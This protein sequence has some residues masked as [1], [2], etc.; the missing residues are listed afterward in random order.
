MSEY[1]IQSETLEDIAD[2][3]RAKTGGSSLIA[4]EDMADVIESIETGGV[5]PTGMTNIGSGSF[6]FAS[7][8]SLNTVINH[9]L[10]FTP[11]FLIVWASDNEVSALE[12]V[13]CTIERELFDVQGGTA[14]TMRC[15]ICFGGSVGGYETTFY[16]DVNA[17]FFITDTSFNIGHGARWYSAGVTYNWFAFA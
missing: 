17:D 11:K 13:L 9:G 15:L 1:L 10:S 5:L 6:T 16:P 12:M 8:T 7:R 2:A 14:K 4:P 3:I